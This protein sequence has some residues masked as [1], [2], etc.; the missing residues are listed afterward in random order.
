ML[1]EYVYDARGIIHTSA[2]VCGNMVTNI[3]SNIDGLVSFF[4]VFI[5]KVIKSN[6]D[7]KQTHFTPH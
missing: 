2:A 4:P 1:A 7:Q 6:Q 5:Q 3:V